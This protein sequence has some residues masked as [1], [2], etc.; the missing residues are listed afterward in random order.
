MARIKG[1]YRKDIVGNW[2]EHKEVFLQLSNERKPRDNISIITSMGYD[3]LRND[4]VKG[5]CHQ[6]FKANFIIEGLCT[7]KITSGS[8]LTIG[9]A[10]VE[11][12]TVGKT[13]HKECPVLT[14]NNSCA[15]GKY[16]FFA[17]VIQS[18]KVKYQDF[19]SP[20]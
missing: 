16:I 4:E 20:V 18:G 12:S 15:L 7:S 9:E 6:K 3:K 1:I 10:L 14:G 13:C 17:K 19:V 11:V 2:A 5:F 8:L